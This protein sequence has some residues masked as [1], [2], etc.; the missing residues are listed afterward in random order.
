MSTLSSPSRSSY[1]KLPNC[2]HAKDMLKGKIPTCQKCKSEK[3]SHY[4]VEKKCLKK[5]LICIA[6]DVEN[7]AGD[8]FTHRFS[9]ILPLLVHPVSKNLEDASESIR[10][11]RNIIKTEITKIQNYVKSMEAIQASIDSSLVSLEA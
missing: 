4:C 9:Y 5:E 6:C 1:S 11:F 2:T 3:L 10:E 7:L 8:H